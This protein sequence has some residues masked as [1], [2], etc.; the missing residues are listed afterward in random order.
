MGASLYVHGS[1]TDSSSDLW[2]R[3][4]MLARVN[5]DPEHGPR[6]RRD[7]LMC[8]T[9]RCVRIKVSKHLG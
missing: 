7:D 3:R 5:Q 6:V 4:Y 9:T 2:G 1:P 8:V